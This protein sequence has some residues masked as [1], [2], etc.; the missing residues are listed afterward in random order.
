[1]RPSGL[2]P[3]RSTSPPSSSPR[4]HARPPS[5]P[6]AVP[7][8][9]RRA[10]QCAAPPAR[11]S[12]RPSGRARSRRSRCCPGIGW[13]RRRRP[14]WPTGRS[15]PRRA[16]EVVLE[17]SVRGIHPGPDPARLL[18]VAPGALGAALGLGHRPV[19]LGTAELRLHLSELPLRQRDLVALRRELALEHPHPL[20]VFG[21][22]ALRHVRRLL[23]LNLCREPTAPL[24]V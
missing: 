8:G 13:R 24:G 20:A 10:S 23:I 4:C 5:P 14:T 7:G 15:R 2:R 22:E 19:A 21:R 1:V 11:S 12:P 6:G 18:Q 16:I 9:D 3:S 17:P